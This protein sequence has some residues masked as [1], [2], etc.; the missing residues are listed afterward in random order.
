MIVPGR[1][2]RRTR[3]LKPKWLRMMMMMMLMMVM[4][5]M[6]MHVDDDDD[7]AVDHGK[8]ARQLSHAHAGCR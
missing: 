2:N 6:M 3:Y 7:V 4:M 1:R 5:M 8:H